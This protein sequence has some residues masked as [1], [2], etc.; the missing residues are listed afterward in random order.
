MANEKYPLTLH[1]P[2]TDGVVHTVHDKA[3]DEAWR[4]Q[5]WRVTEPGQSSAS[6]EESSAS[7]D[8]AKK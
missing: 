6:A 2:H 7:K 1:H 5:G 8:P 4:A 3:D